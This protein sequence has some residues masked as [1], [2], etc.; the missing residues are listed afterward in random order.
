M[1]KI[2]NKGE[3]EMKIVVVK[4]SEEMSKKA[5]RLIGSQVIVKENCVL[6]LATGSTPIGTY[7]DMI[8]QYKEG[9]LDFS[10][11]SVFNLDEYIGVTADNDQS[12][13][14]FMKEN[15]FQHVNIDLAKTNIPSG[16][17][18]DME[19]ECLAYEAKMKAAGGVDLQLLGIGNNGHIGFN[20]P[21]HNF[22][23]R[24]HTVQ[25]TE[26][27]I[28]ANARFFKTK[29]EVPTMAVTMGIKT[30]MNARKVVLVATGKGKAQAIYGTVLGPIDPQ[31]PSSI[32]QLHKDTV[33]VID[34]EA[35]SLLPKEIW[36][37]EV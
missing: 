37:T 35:A 5:G 18:T 10:K 28:E 2:I 9:V 21:D 20:E 22:S 8:A 14:Y 15:L 4:N 26:S 17:A 34:E 29:E 7:Q 27:T 12:Y 6:G 33:L 19:A 1:K 13:A 25:L 32:L 30:I 23:Q 24:T 16:M 36:N 11:V 31:V 3:K